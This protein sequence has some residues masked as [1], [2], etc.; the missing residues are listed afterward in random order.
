MKILNKR[1]GE[2]ICFNVKIA[3]SFF[4]RFFGLMFTFSKKNLLLEFE[5][6]GIFSSSIHMLFMFFSIDALWINSK[7][8]I[9]DIQKNIKPFN[10][11]NLSTWKIYKPKKPAKYVL[12]LGVEKIED[13][14]IKEGD[15]VEFIN[16][17]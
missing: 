7:M 4:S 2:V 16:S 1:T 8:E 9:V 3:N 6:E 15:V 13:K 17:Q 10:P 14:N 5:K 11:L 12:E